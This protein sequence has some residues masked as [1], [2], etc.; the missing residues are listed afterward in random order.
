EFIINDDYRLQY[1]DNIV[2]VGD[3]SDVKKASSL[4]G[5]SPKDLNH[6]QLIP[7]FIGII[8]GV[9]IGSIP[10]SIPGFSHP[11]KLGLAG[12][13][14]IAA[15][16]FSYRQSIGPISWYMPPAGN[17]M[18]RE[19]GIVLFLA[20]VGLKSGESFFSML[21]YGEG[22]KIAVLS[23]LI[24]FIPIMVIGTFMKIRYK[25]NYISLC[26]AL[27]GS[28]TDP[29]ALAFSNSLSPSNASSMSYALVYPWV[30]FL[31]IISTQILVLFFPV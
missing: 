7:V 21:I 29:P 23:F 12:G 15:I 6:P 11:L 18:L 31:R 1:G 9:I 14:L 22:L 10:F 30:M 19:I 13:P 27:A 26:G 24:S 2:L 16:F 3:E 17:L 4:L 20:S 25:T 5:N 28:M 8:V